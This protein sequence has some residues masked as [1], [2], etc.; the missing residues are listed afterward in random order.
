M[1][2]ANS[3]KACLFNRECKPSKVIN[4]WVNR[5]SKPVAKIPV[6]RKAAKREQDYNTNKYDKW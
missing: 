4:V 2:L 5:S 1:N 6:Y 3:F